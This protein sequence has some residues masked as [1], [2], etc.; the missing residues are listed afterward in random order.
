[1]FI[2]N[3]RGYWDNVSITK[4][5]NNNQK[6]AA[7]K[8]RHKNIAKNTR[9]ATA[10]HGYNLLIRQTDLRNERR[11]LAGITCHALGCRIG[12]PL[13]KFS[14]Q[15]W[16]SVKK[17]GHELIIVWR[18]FEYILIQFLRRSLQHVREDGWAV[19]T[20]GLRRC[21]HSCP[22]QREHKVWHLLQHVHNT[23]SFTL[24]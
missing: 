11:H 3:C 19:V 1:M 16:N 10:F 8:L 13:R 15:F 7:C 18:F 9:I 5:S 6:K 4:S 22:H 17:T 20:S 2:K 21:F 24:R 12:S 14:L 23:C